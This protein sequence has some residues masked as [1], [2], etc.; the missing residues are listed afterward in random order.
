MADGAST[1]TP[2]DVAREAAW[3]AYH[4]HRESGAPAVVQDLAYFIADAVVA[5]LSAAGWQI[6][7]GDRL[8]AAEELAEQVERYAKVLPVDGQALEALDVWR[9]G[10]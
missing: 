1:D 10:R 9:R 5:A 3:T 8:E 7:R 4:E 6:V 2:R